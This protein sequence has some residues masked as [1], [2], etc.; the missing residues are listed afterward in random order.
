MVI[1]STATDMER[2][3]CR[4]RER[5]QSLMT[6]SQHFLRYPTHLYKFRFCDL[7]ASVAALGDQNGPAFYGCH[8]GLADSYR[9]PFIPG[10]R[11]PVLRVPH[12]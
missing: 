5:P 4:P 3:D 8:L 11:I 7:A 2:D 10:T 12:A 6:L 1:N 9:L